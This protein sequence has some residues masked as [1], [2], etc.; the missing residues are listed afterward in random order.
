MLMGINSFTLQAFGEDKCQSSTKPID[1]NHDIA[2][3]EANEIHD[4]SELQISEEDKRSK[5]NKAI[6]IIIMP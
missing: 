4:R 5:V 2:L 3:F 1:Y 6:L